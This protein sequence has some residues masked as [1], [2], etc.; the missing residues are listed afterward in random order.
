[1][2]KNKSKPVT[3]E[4]KR[5]H[6]DSFTKILI[7]VNVILALAIVW[8]FVLHKPPA[9]S[10][11]TVAPAKAPAAPPPARSASPDAISGERGEVMELFGLEPLRQAFNADK[12]AIRV[13]E[14]MS[15][16]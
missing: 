5:L 11:A 7:G 10:A 13:V 3:P 1:M 16:G 9:K 2:A 6:R 15:P 8:R 4:A 14:I 12:E